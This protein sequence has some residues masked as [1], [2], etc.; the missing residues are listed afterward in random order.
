MALRE[1]PSL[2]GPLGALIV[3][4]F[5]AVVAVS[6]GDPQAPSFQDRALPVAGEGTLETNQSSDAVA[7]NPE[8]MNK[9]DLKK[10]AEDLGIDIDD[11]LSGDGSSS[12]SGSSASNGSSGSGSENGGSGDST[13]G[14]GSGGNDG[15]S[16]GSENGGN[17]DSSSGNGGDSTADNGSGSGSENGGSGNTGGGTGSGS[18]SGPGDETPP[19]YELYSQVAIQALPKPVDILWVVDSSGS[20]SE[21]QSYLANNFGSLMNALL[22]EGADFQTA[23]TSTDIC[24]KDES[25]SPQCPVAYAGSPST[26]LQG[27]FVGDSGRHVLSSDD[28]DIT[29]K[30]SQYTAVGVNGSGFE[31][32]LQAAEMAVA[33]SENGQNEKLVRDGAFLS[34]IVVSDEEDDGIGL[35]ITDSFSG[36]NY[37]NDGFT[38]HRYTHTDLINYLN[39]VKGAGNFAVSTVTGTRKADGTM[40]T[41][42]HSSPN[43][44]GTQYIKAAE[45]TGGTVQSICDTD[46]SSSLGFIGQDINAQITQLQLDKQ[47]HPPTISVKVNGQAT[48]NWNYIEAT[49]SVKFESAH[50]PAPGSSIE[51]SYYAAP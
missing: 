32:G 17:G 34:V 6:C 30:F 13:A 40:C 39:T 27:D 8:V 23:I 29:S 31:H 4:N 1:T 48:S 42:P 26:R 15:S 3:L 18:G 5:C 16:S 36:V 38:N 11:K 21:E 28:A 49:N 44:E 43:E 35:G 14:S 20:M 22:A 46:W 33:K 2:R 37:V 45:E 10:A 24:N 19:S 7:S 47:A 41:S 50:I 25:F 12:G 51:V 9:E